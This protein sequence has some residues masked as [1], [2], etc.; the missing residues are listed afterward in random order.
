[1]NP[2]VYG[3]ESVKSFRG[4]QKHI[5]VQHSFASPGRIIEIGKGDGHEAT[6]GIKRVSGSC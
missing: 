1:M 5:V 2:V 6:K 3:C 4:L